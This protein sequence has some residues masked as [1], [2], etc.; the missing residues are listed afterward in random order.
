M[1]GNSVLSEIR[2]RPATDADCLFAYELK[3]AVDFDLLTL[4]HGWDEELQWALHQHE[5]NTGLPTVICHQDKPIGTY[6]LLEKR[7]Q[8]YFSRFFI[9]PNYQNQ[10]IGRKVMEYVI[11][12]SKQT[13]KPCSLSYLKDSHAGSLYK[14]M[15]F[16]IYREES[17]FIYTRY[18]PTKC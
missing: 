2:F 10:G 7:D 12:Y 16:E 18:T 6:M 17:P 3:K 15:G 8:I 11:R 5:W 9:L 13:G 1:K 14:R 4:E